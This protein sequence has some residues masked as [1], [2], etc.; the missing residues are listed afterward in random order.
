M[1]FDFLKKALTRPSLLQVA[2]DMLIETELKQLLAI[3]SVEYFTAQERM[4]RERAARLKKDIRTM[5][6][7]D[8]PG[9]DASSVFNQV[10]Q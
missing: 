3:S 4:H 1:A 9:S 6:A 5:T 8:S 2:N 10:D 7:P